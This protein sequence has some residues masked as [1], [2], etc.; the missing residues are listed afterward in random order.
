LKKSVAS[1][2]FGISTQML[3]LQRDLLRLIGRM[4]DRAGCS[5]PSKTQY[6]FLVS[7]FL[8]QFTNCLT[9]P[10]QLQKNQEKIQRSLLIGAKTS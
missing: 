9:Y 10:H 7:E 6:L 2:A 3:I 8:L 1:A 4:A 5:T